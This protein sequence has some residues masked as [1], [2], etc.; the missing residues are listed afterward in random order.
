MSRSLLCHS[1]AE[2]KGSQGKI[3]RPSVKLERR[4]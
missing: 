3:Q 4:K 1:S 2:T